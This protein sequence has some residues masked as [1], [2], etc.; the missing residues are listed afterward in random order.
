MDVQA[1]H[2]RM[3]WRAVTCLLCEVLPAMRS[4][5]LGVKDIA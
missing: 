4:P 1:L 5:F 3:S 2:G